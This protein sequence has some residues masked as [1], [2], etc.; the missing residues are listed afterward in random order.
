[1]TQRFANHRELRSI[2]DVI[3]DSEATEEQLQRLETLVAEDRDARQYLVRQLHLQA[4]LHWAAALAPSEVPVTRIAAL[5]I[6]RALGTAA[7]RVHWRSHHVRFFVAVALLTLMTWC[8]FYF[9]VSSTLQNRNEIAEQPNKTLLPVVAKL[10]QAVDARWAN[11]EQ[12]LTVGQTLKTGQ[13]LELLEGLVEVK[14]ASGARAII[15]G[16]ASFDIRTSNEGYL[17][18]GCLVARVPEEAVGFTLQTPHAKIVDLGTEFGATAKEEHGTQLAVLEGSVEVTIADGTEAPVKKYCVSAGASVNISAGQT[19]VTA[20]DFQPRPYLEMLRTSRGFRELLSHFT[21]DADSN[22]RSTRECPVRLAGSLG[23]GKPSSD[24]RI[25]HTAGD[26]VF[27][28][29][30]VEFGAAPDFVDIPNCGFAHGR[31]WSVAFWAKM[32]SLGK[33]GMV[34]GQRNTT[35]HFI[36][37][38][39]NP[40]RELRWRGDKNSQADF[41]FEMDTNWHHYVLIAHDADNDGKVNDLTLYRDGQTIG[42]VVDRSTGFLICEIGHAYD[43]TLNLDFNGQIDEVWIFG[44]ALGRNAVQAL[45]RDNT[46]VAAEKGKQ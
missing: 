17:E 39:N 45:Y 22:N 36:H 15:K 2:L 6:F 44:R 42:T 43:I 28:G 8:G 38:S 4:S 16:P 3:R 23:G 30:A 19:V 1:M 40:G 34:I 31:P 35:S 18:R 33:E 9:L 7:S 46:P 41:H 24:C 12:T 13:R 25:T 14:F 11:P 32:R 21:F 27:G 5:P 10:W 20:L 37:L 29:G 26:C